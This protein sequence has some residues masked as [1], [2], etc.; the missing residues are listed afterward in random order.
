MTDYFKFS[1]RTFVLGCCLLALAGLETSTALAARPIS[2]SRYH[3]PY[4]S[5]VYR[6]SPR[7]SRYR[8]TSNYPRNYSYYRSTFYGYGARRYNYRYRPYAAVAG[9]R[10]YRPGYYGINHYPAGIGYT[11]AG[12]SFYPRPFCNAWN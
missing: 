2:V 9:Y 1:I 4:S 12:S 6:H 7:Y 3:R 8:Y 5:S 11:W 10:Y